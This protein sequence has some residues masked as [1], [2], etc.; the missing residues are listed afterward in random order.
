[1]VA[2]DG[3]GVSHP[4]PLTIVLLPGLDGSGQFFGCSIS[5]FEPYG[6]VEVL[7]YPN[8]GP[9]DYQSLA[10]G[11]IFKLP[12]GGPF[13][14]VAESFSGPIGIEL[15]SRQIPGLRGLMVVASFAS[16]PLGMISAP[17]M[18]RIRR[19]VSSFSAS[20]SANPLPFALCA[21]AGRFF[22]GLSCGSLKSS[23][24][25]SRKGPS[26]MS[27]EYGASGAALTGV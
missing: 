22:G 14:I 21:E 4:P 24:R 6:N 23:V 26:F 17:G 19:R 3:G 2:G 7:S 20:Q 12:V 18:A 5:Y 10:N 11:L 1:M 27:Q 16:R 8:S 13:V 15:A 9:Q 25:Q